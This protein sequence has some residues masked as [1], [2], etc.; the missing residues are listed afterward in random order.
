MLFRSSFSLASCLETYIGYYL[1]TYL[2]CT[3]HTLL[4]RSPVWSMAKL[5]RTPG[6][7]EFPREDSNLRPC[8]MLGISSLEIQDL[9]TEFPLEESNRRPPHSLGFCLTSVYPQTYARQSAAR[10]H[11][12]MLPRSMHLGSD[13]TR[14]NSSHS[15]ESRM[16][17]SA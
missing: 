7:Y 1:R 9:D 4:P 8:H 6:R 17:S 10:L 5:L 11:G 3:L 15:G 14:L 16:P 13:V 12:L 2:S